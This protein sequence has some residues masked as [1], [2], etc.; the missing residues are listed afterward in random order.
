MGNNFEVIHT[1]TSILY[2]WD[3]LGS[4]I[5]IVDILS[6]DD[7]R[8]DD[9]SSILSSSIYRVFEL[10]CRCAVCWLSWWTSPPTSMWPP[11]SSPWPTQG[12]AVKISIR[13][14]IVVFAHDFVKNG[15]FEIRLF[16]QIYWLAW[17]D[18]AGKITTFS[19]PES[20]L[21]PCTQFRRV[22]HFQKSVKINLGRGVL[23][24]N[25]GNAQKQGFFIWQVFS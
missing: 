1:G 24:P 20:K 25:L 22:F 7:L 12:I 10:C 23:P 5:H 19:Q 6:I 8:I 17:M 3:I 11:G 9:Q 21:P 4:S 13:F 18:R 16:H 15:Q 14:F 2:D